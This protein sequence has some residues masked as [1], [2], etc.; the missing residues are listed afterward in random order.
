M[1]CCAV[2]YHKLLFISPGWVVK[3]LIIG[4]GFRV[5]RVRF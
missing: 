5:L 4:R 2:D 1:I 3:C